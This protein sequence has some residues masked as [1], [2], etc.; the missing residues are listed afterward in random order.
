MSCTPLRIVVLLIASLATLAAAQAAGPD[1]HP[2]ALPPANPA[3]HGIKALHRHGQTFVTW[4]DVAEGEAGA[5]FRYSLYRSD[6]PITQES[7]AQ[8]ELCY[9]GVFNNS[10]K[11]FGMAYNSKDRLDPQKPT[12]ILEEG[13]TPLPMWSGL[14][15]RTVVANGKSYYAVVATDDKGQ[16]RSQVVPGESAT[17][18]ALEEQVAPIEPIK[19]YDSKT[20]GTYAKQLCITGTKNLPLMVSLH[21]SNATGGMA[22]AQGDYYIYFGTPE[23][24]YRDGLPGAFAIEES[25]PADGKGSN[26]LVL[27]NRDTIEHP[28]GK[29]A[30]ETYWFGY[31]CTPQGAA[32][33]EAR[34]YPFTE[35]R[36]LWTIDWVCKVYGVDRNRIY[37]AGQSMGGWGSTSLLFRHSELFAGLWPTLPRTRQRGLVGISTYK[38]IDDVLMA[39]GK[40]PYL[41]RMDSVK[42]AESHHEDLPFYAW[43]IGR[44][45]GFATWKEEV[46]MV[47]ALTSAHHGLAMSWNDGGH[48]DGPAPMA[49]IKKYYPCELFALDRS[50]PALGNSSIDDNMGT[51]ELAGKDLKEGDGDKE[52]SINLGFAWSDVTDD[53]AAWSV[54]I[55]NDLCK[56]PM[57]VDVTPRRCQKFVAKAGE[58]F[59]WT[60]SAGASGNV[61]ADEFGLVTVAKVAIDPGKATLLTIKR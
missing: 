32:P 17:T 24:G 41:Q 58:K 51:G 55:S 54:K 5:D 45:D 11:M 48:S 61:T 57:T 29:Q 15:V 16:T 4:A 6:K 20:Y 50:Y 10:A 44:H 37:G 26:T 47:K 13:G 59:T 39:D 31:Y 9:S 19:I 18:Q 1:T 27:R 2:A 46:D 42:F 52:G 7:L 14:A 60:T 23:M 56:G 3:V 40:T 30:M 28:N 25:R 33:T 12:M 38:K 43:S 8:A 49:K 36:V 53:A 22:G 34:A 21:A 35:N